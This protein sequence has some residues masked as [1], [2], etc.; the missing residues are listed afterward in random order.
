M[1]N[2]TNWQIF[3]FILG[4]VGYFVGMIG[5]ITF[6]KNNTRWFYVGVISVIVGFAI[7]IISAIFTAPA[8]HAGVGFLNRKV[9][10]EVFIDGVVELNKNSH[11]T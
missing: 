3:G 9:P 5:L 10:V 1:E 11:Y 7:V 6:K 4:L 2:F 8:N